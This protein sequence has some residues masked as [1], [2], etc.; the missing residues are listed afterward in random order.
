[1][2]RREF[3][4][5][6]AAVGFLPTL[7]IATQAVATT[8]PTVPAG[9]YAWAHLIAR[10]QTKCSPAMLARQLHL[11]PEVARHLFNTMISDG[12]LKAPS[13]AGIATATKPI[14]ATGTDH[15]LARRLHSNLKGALDSNLPR[16]QERVQSRE[17]PLAK[18]A[19]PCLGCD[20]PQTEDLRDASTNQSVQESP[21][22]G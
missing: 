4:A 2:N 15:S 8:A 13:A 6:L 7:P 12:V 20:T 18:D 3:T 5:S 10:A 9:A 1:M 14:N 11:S 22:R 16:T 19:E 17:P 21:E